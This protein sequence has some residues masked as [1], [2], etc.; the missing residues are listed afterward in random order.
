MKIEGAYL[1]RQRRQVVGTEMREGAYEYIAM[2]K[3]H[4][5]ETYRRKGLFGAYSSRE[6]SLSLSQ[7]G[8][9]HDNPWAEH[10]ELEFESSL[11]QPQTR[12]QENDLGIAE[13]FKPHRPL[14]AMH[15]LHQ[16]HTS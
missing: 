16:V 11:F 10:L 1:R 4:D 5:Q 2:I 14:P 12:N 9:K 3:H 13:T 7:Q 8:R 15:F 6:M